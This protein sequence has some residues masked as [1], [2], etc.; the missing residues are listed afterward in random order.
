MA[1]DEEPHR[2]DCSEARREWCDGMVAAF[3]RP[4]RR[5][6][7]DD[8]RRAELRRHGVMLSDAMVDDLFALTTAWNRDRNDRRLPALT[9]Y[10]ALGELLSTTRGLVA[11][12]GE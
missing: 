4:K 7:N 12:K 1:A 8:P 9:P 3:T 11:G 10:Q 6:P 5:P 2:S